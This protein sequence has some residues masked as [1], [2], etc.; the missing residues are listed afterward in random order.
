MESPLG[1]LSQVER[2]IS[3]FYGVREAMNVMPPHQTILVF[4]ATPGAF[5]RFPEIDGAV[6]LWPEGDGL[7]FCPNEASPRFDMVMRSKLVSSMRAAGVDAMLP[8]E[9]ATLMDGYVVPP[10]S[11]GT[12]HE[13]L[14][15]VQQTKGLPYLNFQALEVQYLQTARVAL[16]AGE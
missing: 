16:K 9:R 7:T 14:R 2:T 5:E 13:V 12:G 15:H 3:V 11:R 4:Y 8:A 10:E 1:A 6:V